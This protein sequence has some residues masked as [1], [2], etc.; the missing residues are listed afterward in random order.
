MRG[1]RSS[2]SGG[3]SSGWD[4]G[5]R[6]N[7]TR[8]DAW[9]AGID[10]GKAVHGRGSGDRAGCCWNLPS[11]TVKNVTHA[12]AVTTTDRTTRVM[13]EVGWP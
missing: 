12:A 9:R 4:S 1:K 2:G 8:H 6:G 11:G 3:S 13:D 10:T 5:A 7:G